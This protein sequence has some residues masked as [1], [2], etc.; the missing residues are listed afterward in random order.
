M[1]V[2]LSTALATAITLEGLLT[3]GAALIAIPA[4]L[5]IAYGVMSSL[6]KRAEKSI[7]KLAEGGIVTASPGGKLVTVGEGGKD[8]A[9]IPLNTPRAERLMGG[10]SNVDLSPMIA[11]I[12]EVRTAVNNLASRPSVAIIDGKNAFADDLGKTSALGT[13][14]YKNSY[15]LA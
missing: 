7:P 1:V 9:I 15:N 8:E 3:A 10:V 5:G 4:L 13:S 12:N 6:Q 11:A 14:Q 2:N